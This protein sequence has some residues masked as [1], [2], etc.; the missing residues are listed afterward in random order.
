MGHA[1]S[2]HEILV[3][4]REGV[5]R[6]FAIRR[7]P[8]DQRWNGGELQLVQGSPAQPNSREMRTRDTNTHQHRRR[9]NWEGTAFREDEE[10]MPRRVFITEVLLRKCGCTT[11]CK[12]FD[13]KKKREAAKKGHGETRR[14][15]FEEIMMKTRRNWTK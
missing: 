9:A 5:V 11:V 7:R 14:K 12:G 1:S 10:R 13:A 3:E 15:R 2:A 8:E 4:T 6:A